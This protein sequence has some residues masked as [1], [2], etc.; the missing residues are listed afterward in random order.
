[1]QANTRPPTGSEEINNAKNSSKTSLSPESLLTPEQIKEIV[2]S[3][4]RDPFAVLGMH[5][6]EAGISVRAFRPEARS[7]EVLP[8]GEDRVVARMEPVHDD[9]LFVGIISGSNRLFPYDL[10]ITRP[11]GSTTLEADSYGC[12]PLMS[13]EAR[14]LF[15]EGNHLKI[16][17]DLGSHIRTIDGVEGVVFAVWAPNAR[18]VSVV[19]DFNGWDGRVHQMRLLGSSGVWELFIPGIGE[20]AVYKYEI[21]VR[22]GSLLLKTDPYGY[23]QEPFPNHAGVVFD[24][25]AY[26]WADE[27]WMADRAGQDLLQR[28]LSIYEVHLGSWRRGANGEWLSYDDLAAQLIAYVKEAGFTHVELLPVQEHPYEP[29]WGYQVSG[30][31]APNHRF[32]D[33]RVFQRFVD[34]LHRHGIGVIIDW[35]PGHF[36]KDQFGLP[37]FDGT[38]LY[39]HQDPREGEHQDWGTLIFNYGRHEVRNFLLANALFWCEKFHVDGLRV[40]AVA[41]MLYRNYSRREGEW[42]PN[43][44]GGVDNIEAVDFLKAVNYHVHTQFPGVMTIAEESTAWPMVSRP[45]YL[46]GLGFTYKWNMGWMHDTLTYFSKDPVYRKYHHDQITFGLWYAFTENFVLVL[47]HDEVVHGKR[48]LLQKMPGDHWSK[49]ANLR[50]LLAYMY[51]HPGKKLLFQ[52]GEFGMH[53]EWWEQRSIDWHLL[54]GAEEDSWLHQGLHRLVCDL[55]RLYRNEPAL[56]EHDF[57]ESGFTWIDHNDRDGNIVS[58]IRHGA[59]WHNL[60]VFACNFAP[61]VRHD[62][63]IGVPHSGYYEEILNSDAEAYGGSGHGNWGGLRASETPWHGY[64]YTLHLTLPPLSVV[65]FKWRR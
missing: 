11:D 5:P 43:K 22:D 45:T 40:D 56:W 31:Y 4:T 63:L 37:R 46:G 15:G 19:G 21:K 33:P 48:S 30:F 10:R 51:A 54:E 29:S 6:E 55:N 52:G 14:Y 47:S 53:G 9:G 61:V 50:S 28:P 7:I 17:E 42:I 27:S 58:F 20:G 49:F 24:L 65:G 57:D 32:G 35:V 26:P 59:E 18:R 8:R 13:E 23:Y 3:D 2:E 38:C 60:L 36:P 39:E 25:D 62:Y 41:S 1:M 44:Y 34:N 12:L 16:Y 64:N